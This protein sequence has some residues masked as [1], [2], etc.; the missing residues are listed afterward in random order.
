MDDLKKLFKRR[1]SYN[2]AMKIARKYYQKN[3]YEEALRWTKRANRLNSEP[4]DSWI[5]YAKILQHMGKKKRAM[6]MLR[7][8]LE[9]KDSD[10]VKKIL[11]EMQ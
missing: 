8:Y 5:L 10:R 1:E 11:K 2:L 4:E 6:Q 3:E 7:V 9:Y